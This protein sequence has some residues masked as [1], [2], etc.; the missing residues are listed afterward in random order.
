MLSFTNTLL[1]T[2]LMA[3]SIMTSQTEAISINNLLA[4]SQTSIRQ[5]V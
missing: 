4:Q 2:C 1:R 3:A 5:E